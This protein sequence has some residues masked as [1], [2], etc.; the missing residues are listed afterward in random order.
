MSLQDS[1]PNNRA[2]AEPQVAIQLTRRRRL[3]MMLK[4]I[5]LRL[6]FIVLV[7]ATGLFFASW[8]TLVNQV[9]K[10]SRPKGERYPP[11]TS[12]AGVESFCPM[13]PNVVSEQSGQCPICGMPL[14][15]RRRA[16]VE[17]LPARVLSRVRLAPGQIAQAGIRTVAV[18]FGPAVDRL[19]TIGRVGFDDSRRV[20]VTSEG[21]G[22][23]RIE[24]LHVHSEGE[25]VRAG[26]RLAELYSYDVAQSIRV[27]LEA[28]SAL[29]APPATRPD[30]DPTPLGDPGE[31]F[32][33]AS[34]SL[35]VL[36]VRQDQIAA[37]AADNRPDGLLP[38]LAPIGGLVIKKT[39]F[40]GQY[41]PEG[42]LLF[43]IADV[44]HV[45]VD[46]EVFEEQLALVQVGRPV[47]A[48]VPAFP[49]EEFRGH[50]EQLAP[51]LDPATRTLAV[52]FGLDN[53]GDRLR[54]GMLATVAFNV[55]R[56][57]T[58]LAR[59]ATCPVT[60]VQLGT[61]GPAIPVEIRGR[62]I[63][64]CCAACV[65]TL[66]AA[67]ET[68]LDLDPHDTATPDRVLSVPE[69]AVVHTGAKTIVYVEA[70]PG[71]FEGRDVL[72]G[73]RSGDSF[74]VLDGLGP[75]DRIAA[76]GAFLIDAETRLNPPSRS[77]GG[78]AAADDPR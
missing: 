2:L 30:P 31:R 49:G 55:D 23:A 69:L 35:Q 44:G 22:R 11:S 67:P 19:T 60:R 40:Q 39:A 38:L 75:G 28:T 3:G 9:E 21:R 41:V 36:G 64:V 8:D 73:P 32:R 56:R 42:T 77:V 63:S 43:E 59:S 70:S 17:Q 7:A 6:R 26:Q 18:S 4:V 5:E 50:V 13:H 37:I 54:P 33:L 12:P 78:S 68:Y 76:A 29:H 10:W 57:V 34:Q 66:K 48:T 51:A 52:R 61:M 74:P 45:W 27:L 58:T 62:T 24:R 14:A 46:A 16:G 72:L 65:P 71:V 15:R 1:S 20:Q 25:R 53:P 47:A